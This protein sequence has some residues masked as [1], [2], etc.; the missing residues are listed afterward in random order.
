MI[1]DFQFDVSLLN[2]TRNLN[3]K[4]M[5]FSIYNDLYSKVVRKVSVS[6]QDVI[7]CN[8]FLSVTFQIQLLETSS[9]DEAMDCKDFVDN[10]I[11]VLDKFANFNTG[12]MLNDY[13]INLYHIV[14]NMSYVSI[15]DSKKLDF[16][17]KTKWVSMIND[18]VNNVLFSV[19][20]FYGDEESFCLKNKILNN[21]LISIPDIL[22]KNSQLSECRKL[23][24]EETLKI[25]DNMFLNNEFDFYKFNGILGEKLTDRFDD[26]ELSILMLGLKPTLAG[27]SKNDPDMKR[28]TGEQASKLLGMSYLKYIGKSSLVMI[29]S[30]KVLNSNVELNEEESYKKLH[31][32]KN[33][34]K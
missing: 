13:I 26:D 18:H 16:E 8:D 20:S 14:E 30:F 21:L 27:Y 15:I 34:K 10:Y 25:I 11:R 33:K 12:D 22:N 9:C 29:K 7:S 17:S 28:L 5:V 6:N 24:K 23:L 31:K 32:R 2:N 1:H 4:L 19:S 3:N